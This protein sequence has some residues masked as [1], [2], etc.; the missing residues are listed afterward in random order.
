MSRKFSGWTPKEILDYLRIYGDHPDIEAL[1]D[2]FESYMRLADDLCIA[3][4]DAGSFKFNWESPAEYIS[5]LQ[6]DIE[7]ANDDIGALR[8]EVEVL[9]EE[10]AHERKKTSAMT[11]LTLLQE[12]ERTTNEA[13]DEARR[14][15]IEMMN[16]KDQNKHLESQM[17]TWNILCTPPPDR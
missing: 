15:R 8:A 2:A 12:A 17:N 9:E 4:M 11:V 14:C 6:A 1:V 3:G 13:R 7:I 10:L 5:G 16:L